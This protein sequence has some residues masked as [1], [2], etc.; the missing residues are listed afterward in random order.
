LCSLSLSR[1]LDDGQIPKSQGSHLSQWACTATPVAI[2]RTV[3]GQPNGPRYVFPPS[4]LSSRSFSSQHNY[5]YLC[6]PRFP[7][8]P[9]TSFPVSVTGYPCTLNIRSKEALTLCFH[10]IQAYR[11]GPFDAVQLRRRN[12]FVK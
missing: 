5:E 3:S 6:S 7:R 12:S 9:T 1:I 10:I 4:F 11:P 8:R 2:H